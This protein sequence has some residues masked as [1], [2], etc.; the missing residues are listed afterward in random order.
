MTFINYRLFEESSEVAG[1]AMLN[2]YRH[3]IE[4]GT[5]LWIRL[6]AV[7]PNYQRKGLNRKQISSSLVWVIVME[8][9]ELYY[10]EMYAMIK[11]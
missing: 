4:I 11:L 3:D 10:L 7:K 8:R 1:L 6:I 2:L 9:S 5:A